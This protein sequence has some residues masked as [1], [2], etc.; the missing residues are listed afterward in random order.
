[1]VSYSSKNSFHNFSLGII[2]A[3]GLQE[4][5]RA[6]LSQVTH[7]NS[8]TWQKK[9]SLLSNFSPFLLFCLSLRF[10]I[11]LRNHKHGAFSALSCPVPLHMDFSANNTKSKQNTLRFMRKM[12]RNLGF[13]QRFA[14]GH[15][16]V[17][18]REECLSK[19]PKIAILWRNP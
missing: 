4:D 10:S 17:V 13:L 3:L 14:F 2:T 19:L 9:L 16:L 11:L 8:Y 1:M 18:G 7:M 6:H 12:V 5:H 15:Q